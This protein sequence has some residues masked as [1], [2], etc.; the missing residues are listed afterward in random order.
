MPNFFREPLI[1][2][3]FCSWIFLN[4]PNRLESTAYDRLKMYYLFDFC[5]CL[6]LILVLNLG[7]GG[8]GIAYKL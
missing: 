7:R 2:K 5:K 6:K 4:K 3:L 1:L 8:G